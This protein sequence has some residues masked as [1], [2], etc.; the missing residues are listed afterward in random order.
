MAS[1]EKFEIIRNTQTSLRELCP[2]PSYF[3]NFAKSSKA[4][5]EIMGLVIVVILIALG[6]LFALRFMLSGEQTD[7][8]KEVVES[9]LASNIM[10]A[11]LSTTTDCSAKN[12]ITMAELFQDCA[13]TNSI[14]CD[15]GEEACTTVR[16]TSEFML[17]A[18]LGEGGKD[19][20]FQIEGAAQT[21]AR[22]MLNFSNHGAC[23][24]L[25]ELKTVPMPTKVGTATLKLYLCK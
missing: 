5:M 15:S 23:G 6:V 4:Q 25:Y 2:K 14:R 19:Y 17:N 18:T 16:W 3:L 20:H 12:P 10:N 13:V 9:E 11:M 22:A 21:E 7:I 1:K 8:R 24:R